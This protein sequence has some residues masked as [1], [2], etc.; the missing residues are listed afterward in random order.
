[1]K[2]ERDGSVDQASGTQERVPS[3]GQF[4]SLS[5]AISTGFGVLSPCP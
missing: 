3:M 2:Q 1:M 4:R 5:T